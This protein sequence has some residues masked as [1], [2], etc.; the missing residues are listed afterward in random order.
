VSAADAL[1]GYQFRHTIGDESHTMTAHQG[2][3]KVGQVIWNDTD[4]S[5]LPPGS[6]RPGFT[7]LAGEIFWAGVQPDHRG[8]GLAK[9]MIRQAHAI[10][11]RVHHGKAVSPEGEALVRSTPEYGAGR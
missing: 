10:D 6:S 5:P 2:G 3:Q 7:P 9:E 11:P 8:H 1:N 4:R